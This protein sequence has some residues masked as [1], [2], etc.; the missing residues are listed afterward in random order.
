V[1]TQRVKGASAEDVGLP[2]G[3]SEHSVSVALPLWRHVVEYEEQNPAT[4][5]RMRCG[6]PRFF[7]HPWVARAHAQL[8]EQFCG[9]KEAAIAL[10]SSGAARRLQAFMARRMETGL[11]F[12]ELSEQRLMVAAFPE[13]ASKLALEYWRYSGDGISSR[14]AKA[15]VEG[16]RPSPQSRNTLDTLCRRLANL[17]GVAASDVMLT[18]TGMTSIISLH[19]LLTS[20]ATPDQRCVQLGF[21]YVDGWRVLKEF[22]VGAQLYPK[23]SRDDL[24]HVADL[25]HQNQVAAIFCEFPNNPLMEPMNLQ[26]IA[27]F[28]RPNRVPVVVDDTLSGPA[29]T[30]LLPHADIITTSLTKLFT[31]T[32]NAMGGAYILNPQSP[33]H[34]AIRRAASALD[35]NAGAL[36]EE[37]LD[38]IERGSRDYLERAA[39]VNSNAA[40]LYERLQGDSRIDQVYYPGSPENREIYDQARR[41]EG[42]YTQMLSLILKRPE[43]TSEPFYDRLNVAKGP[44]LG[45]NF[46]L[47]CPYTLL[48]H[49]QELGWAESCGVSR[50]LIRISVGLENPEDLWERFRDALDHAFQ[51]VSR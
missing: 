51:T 17:Y 40:F 32:T 35:S 49:Y 22:G 23:V 7:I 31:G 5:S 24:E 6:Y 28:A 48:A 39:K 9:P 42:G 27:E 20:L 11:R 14:H 19:E 16:R 30:D 2:I 38:E 25:A 29:N 34:E 15:L 43:K 33:H 36:W 8:R 12:E 21:P 4:V 26:K 47:A 41:P 37:D 1:D 18:P 45:A 46:T 44:S 10:S 50:W 3:D 13:D